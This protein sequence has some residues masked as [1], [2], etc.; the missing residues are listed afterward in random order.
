MA[1]KKK[2][3][4]GVKPNRTGFTPGSLP[5]RNFNRTA[6]L[7]SPEKE[8][9]GSIDEEDV[10]EDVGSFHNDN[11][12]NDSLEEHI[13]STGSAKVPSISSSSSSNQNTPTSIPS[14]SSNSSSA[15]K[16]ST[17]SSLDTS[18]VSHFS[19][20]L[21]IKPCREERFSYRYGQYC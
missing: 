15:K 5:G 17:K 12:D 10:Q 3:H 21:C 20:I 19:S 8:I 7:D 16:S 11:D 4:R 18:E 2:N 14:K 13:F 6:G 9:T 1:P